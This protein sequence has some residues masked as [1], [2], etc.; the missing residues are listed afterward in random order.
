MPEITYLQ[1]IHDAIEE[2]MERDE[3]ILVMGEDIH[4]GLPFGVTKGL[5]ERFGGERVLNTPIS[6]NSFMGAA[7]GAALTGMRPVVEFQFDN[8]MMLAMDQI[9]NQAAKL[10]YM[11]GGQLKIPVVIRSATGH[12]GSFAAQHSDSLGA[13]FMRIPGLTLVA[14]SS[15]R[16]AKGLLKTSIRADCPVIFLEHKKL[17]AEKGEVP[18]EEELIPLGRAEVKREGSDV[19]L[20]AI[21]HMVTKALQAA[22][23]LSAEG[24][25]VEVVDP[26]TLAP[27]EKETILASVRKTGRLVIA[28]EGPKTSG[29][30][31]EIAAL[32]AEEA[33]YDLE[34]PI[35]RV[36]ALDC[37]VPF[38]PPLE[39]YMIPGTEEIVA[40]IGTVVA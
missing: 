8:L 30:G 10:R 32:T 18:E 20:V 21:S 24:I 17:Y 27:I 35:K 26:R 13:A 14:P 6:E 31:A 23:Q 33:I 2:E 22:E 39:E 15:A 5:Y 34:A 38:S 3:S 9:A 25:A 37:P 11:S 4:V 36:A 28:E 40:A 7:I 29:V 1:A 12:W 16:D 19:T